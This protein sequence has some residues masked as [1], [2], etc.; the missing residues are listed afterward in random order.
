M[1]SMT[2]FSES[3]VLYEA[4]GK[5]ELLDDADREGELVEDGMDA[6]LS[7]GYRSDRVLDAETIIELI[8]EP[9]A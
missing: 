6:E 7:S 4:S 8:D 3:E 5:L 9:S 2:S 1:V